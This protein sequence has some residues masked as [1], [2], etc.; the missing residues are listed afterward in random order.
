VFTQRSPNLPSGSRRQ[1]LRGLAEGLA[2]VTLAGLASETRADVAAHA[3][4]AASTAVTPFRVAVPQA[5]IDDLKQRLRRVRFPEK[6]TVTD[7]TQ[8]VPLN[9]AKAL[10][11]YW[12]DHYDWRRFERRLNAV[13]QFRT[14]IDGLGIH[15]IHVRSKHPGALP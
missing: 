15:F 7:W 4:P 6:E 3:T 8:G 13:P 5:A 1:A 12:R 11:A 9:K 14:Q 10:I 2:V